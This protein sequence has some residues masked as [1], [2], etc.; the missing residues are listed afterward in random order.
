M[1]L[2]NEIET[3]QVIKI[4]VITVKRG[5]GTKQDPVRFVD[6]YWDLDGN[7]MFVN[8]PILKN[9]KDELLLHMPNRNQ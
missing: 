8:D 9:L 2:Q 5:E 4:I 1:K 7:L 6:Q 3:L